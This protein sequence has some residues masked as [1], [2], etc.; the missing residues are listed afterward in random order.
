MKIYK[1]V[2]SAYFANHIFRPCR[3][4][5]DAIL[6]CIETLREILITKPTNKEFDLAVSIGKFQRIFFVSENKIYS[7]GFPYSLTERDDGYLSIYY[8]GEHEVTNGLLASADTIVKQHLREIDSDFSAF[9]DSM[10]EELGN[11][12]SAWNFL[13]KIIMQEDSYLRYDL[14][15]KRADDIKK[16]D[17][18]DP[19]NPKVV[20]H[21]LHHIDV[22]Y[23]PDHTFK[24]GLQAS[25]NLEGILDIL[26]P[27]TKCR[28]LEA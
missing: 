14:D 23:N 19:I 12:S 25:L 22:F 18:P 27:A 2:M 26:D 7:V 4:K 17:I 3:K 28:T 11:D 8:N 20:T 15:E 1:F 6:N 24:I 21:P 16:E 9:F 5:S 10:M 13:L